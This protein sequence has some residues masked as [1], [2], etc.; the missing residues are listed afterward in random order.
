MLD[1]WEIKK[2]DPLKNGILAIKKD[3]SKLWVILPN[4]SPLLMKWNDFFWVLDKKLGEKVKEKDYI[5]Y[6][7]ETK[8][9]NDL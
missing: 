4:V 9:Y 7:I 8:I 2:L 1:D 5:L 6:V 3:Y